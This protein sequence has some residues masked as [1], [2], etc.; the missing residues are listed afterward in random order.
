MLY[1]IIGTKA[2]LI[3]MAPLMMYFHEQQIPYRYI[4]TGQHQETME[5]IH[6]NFG[7]R[8]PDIQLYAG[9]D[10]T[11]IVQMAFWG[12]RLLLKS[13]FQRKHIFPKRQKS[14]VLVHGDTFSTLI[15]ALMGALA[16]LKVGHVESGLRSYN[17]FHP[18]PEEIIRI[19]TFK[20]SDYFFCPGEWAINNLKKERGVKINTQ[21]NTLYES[22]QKALPVIEK[23]SDVDIPAN[24]YA[25]VTLHRYENVYKFDTFIRV[26]ELV[27]QIANHTP[28]LFILHKL[29]VKKLHKFQ[30]YTRLQDNPNIEL[31]PRYDYFRFIK[32]LSCAYFV[33]SDGGSN[34]EECSY[35]GKPLILLRRS[36]ERKEGLGQNCLLSNYDPDL[37]NNFLTNMNNYKQASHGQKAFPCSIIADA[38]KIFY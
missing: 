27:E 2:Q 34:Q 35:L 28:V 6:V 21:V 25:V 5:D 23:I 1:V 33:V 19:L 16:G 32:L 7:L 17:Y 38:C 24:R 9:K 14:I 36:T 29:T 31:R 37:I 12:G 10:I 3:K 26:I 20:L 15:G 18:F 22:L 30:I 4:S 8:K 11:G 13:L